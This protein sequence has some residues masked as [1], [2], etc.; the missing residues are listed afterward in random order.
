VAITNTVVLI[1]LA[2]ICTA[3]MIALIVVVVETVAYTVTVEIAGA[4]ALLIKQLHAELM[5]GG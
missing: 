2:A 3:V 1:V 5:R 4:E